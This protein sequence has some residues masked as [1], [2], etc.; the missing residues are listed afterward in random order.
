M[1]H[2]PVQLEVQMLAQPVLFLVEDIQFQI[3][4]TTL[5]VKLF[6][7]NPH[8]HCQIIMATSKFA[9]VNEKCNKPISQ[10]YFYENVNEKCNTP[11]PNFSVMN[12][13]K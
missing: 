4:C 5:N 8:I 9:N 10:L 13:L 6:Y 7:I 12:M 1:Q 11:I 2:F 3:S